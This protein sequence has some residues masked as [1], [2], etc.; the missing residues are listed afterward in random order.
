MRPRGLVVCFRDPGFS[1]VYFRDP[2]FSVVYFRDP[3][4]SVVYFRDPGFASSGVRMCA[5]V[6]MRI[7]KNVHA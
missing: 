6:C 5:H 3:G 4:F 2:G 1:V 7:Y